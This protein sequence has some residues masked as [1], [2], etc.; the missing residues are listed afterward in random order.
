MNDTK[1][2]KIG[3]LEMGASRPLVLIAGPCVIE[4]EKVTRAIAE[5][6]KDIV[7]QTQALLEKY[8]D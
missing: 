3:N 5:A 4:D 1:P 7:E 8:K 6:L 2:V